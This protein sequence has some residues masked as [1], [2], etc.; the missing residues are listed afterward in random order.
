MQG[1]W[2]SGEGVVSLPLVHRR[3]GA[4]Q[5]TLRYFGIEMG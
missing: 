2:C 4:E 1:K 3:S 5:K